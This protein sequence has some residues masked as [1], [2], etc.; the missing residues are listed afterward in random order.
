MAFTLWVIKGQNWPFSDVTS[1]SKCIS[2]RQFLFFPFFFT[3]TSSNHSSNQSFCS[4]LGF[5]FGGWRWFL[6]LTKSWDKRN[7]AGNEHVSNEESFNET[8]NAPHNPLGFLYK[9]WGGSVGPCVWNVSNRCP[10]YKNTHVENSG[11]CSNIKQAFHKGD[12]YGVYLSIFIIYPV[13]L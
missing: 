12:I 11:A 8:A 2:F 3:K 7:G 5:C 13:F 9:K 1:I 4:L 10:Q 6:S